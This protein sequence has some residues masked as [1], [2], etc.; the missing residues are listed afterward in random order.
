[1]KASPEN[2]KIKV[3]KILEKYSNPDDWASNMEDRHRELDELMYAYLTKVGCKEGVDLI[4][5]TPKWYS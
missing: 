5:A 1:M 3:E 4:K 2:F